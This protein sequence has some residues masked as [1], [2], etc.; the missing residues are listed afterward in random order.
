MSTHLRPPYM[1]PFELPIPS[2]WELHLGRFTGWTSLIEAYTHQ[3]SLLIAHE[4]ANA[5]EATGIT[6]PPTCTSHT[7]WETF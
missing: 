7:S 4:V 5:L 2:R 3:L 6:R 1:L